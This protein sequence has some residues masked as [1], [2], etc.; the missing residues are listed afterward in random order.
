MPDASP[1]RGEFSLI[2]R[3]FSQLDQG[4][5]V[6]LGNGDD[7]AILRLMPG[8]ELVV[9][10][11]SMLEGVHFP[12]A[13]PPCELAYRAVAAAASDLAAMGARPVAMTLA[14][15]LPDADDDWLASCRSG[16]AD[17]VTAFSLP[18]VGG[19]LTRGPLALSV[20][21]LGAVPAGQGRRHPAWGAVPP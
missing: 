7:G 10:V 1:S 19:D 4:P 8:E 17:A 14:L 13:S 12:V 15:S 18:L 11:D 5:D 20:Q 2:A 3:Y 9:S 16:L 6:V 21:V